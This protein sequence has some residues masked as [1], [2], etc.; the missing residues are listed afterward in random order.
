MA[1]ASVLALPG[2]MFTPP[3]DASGQRQLRVA[4]ANLDRDGIGTL[5]SRLSDLNY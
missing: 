4:F 1:D 2:T 3:E 5:I